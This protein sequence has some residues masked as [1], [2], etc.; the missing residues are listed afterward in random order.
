MSFG[1]VLEEPRAMVEVLC[2]RHLGIRCAIP[3]RQV[4]GARPLPAAEAIV[5]LWDTPANAS[6]EAAP[7]ALCLRTAGGPRWIRATEVTVGW[8]RSE[9]AHALPRLLRGL[10]PLAHVVGIADV[11]HELTWLVDA[12]RFVPGSETERSASLPNAPESSPGPL[13]LS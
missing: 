6:L 5:A 1:R 2:F 9:H 13:R 4:L 10:I 8:L 12:E 3:S 11:G 7:R